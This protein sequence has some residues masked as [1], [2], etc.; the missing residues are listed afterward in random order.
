LNESRASSLHT[1]IK[2][3]SLEAVLGSPGPG[4]ETPFR[5]TF[6]M[7]ITCITKLISIWKP[8]K[9]NILL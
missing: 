7:Y 6:Y 2:Q 3:S 9:K 5:R 4:F 1:R 8:P